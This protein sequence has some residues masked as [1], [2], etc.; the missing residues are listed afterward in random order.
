LQARVK[1]ELSLAQLLLDRK[2]KVIAVPV[3]GL[4]LLHAVRTVLNNDEC[5]DT[6]TAD[7]AEQVR[8]EVRRNLPHYEP[9][10]QTSL[11][12]STIL[13]NLNAYFDAG[14]YDADVERGF[15]HM[16]II[17]SNTRSNL[18]LFL[19]CLRSCSSSC[20]DHQF[21]CGGLYSTHRHG[22]AITDL[23]LTQRHVLFPSTIRWPRLTHIRC[24][25]FSNL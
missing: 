24:G 2:L 10:F 1:T 7:I 4:C 25:N 19:M 20:M 3:D 11:S 17:V 16:N 14:K 15:S 5:F 8:S 6:T 13:K 9:F 18:E 23:Q 21:L 12:S 22:S